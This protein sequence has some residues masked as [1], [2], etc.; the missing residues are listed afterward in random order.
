ML[1]K[2]VNPTS[3]Q[4]L[5]IDWDRIIDYIKMPMTSFLMIPYDVICAKIAVDSN[6]GIYYINSSHLASSTKAEYQK[7]LQNSVMIVEILDSNLETGR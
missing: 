3:P 5:S 7:K 1:G 4:I 6:S 2:A